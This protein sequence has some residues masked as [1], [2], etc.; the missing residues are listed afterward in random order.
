MTKDEGRNS[1]PTRSGCSSFVTQSAK[2]H[3]ARAWCMPAMK[4]P[5]WVPSEERKRQA[6][7]T[8]FV[9]Q[10]NNGN[11]SV[12]TIVFPD[13]SILVEPTVQ[14]LKDKLGVV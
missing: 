1:L 8:R 3:S 9:E 13:G 10:V 14:Q 5:L 7:L 4:T 6:N 2:A 12:P 11:R